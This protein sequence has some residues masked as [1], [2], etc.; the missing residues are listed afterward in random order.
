[1]SNKEKLED[2]LTDLNNMSK[3]VVRFKQKLQCNFKCIE[4]I[5]NI[6]NI[7]KQPATVVEIYIYSIEI[8]H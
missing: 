2:L 7:H 3:D 1:M 8:K 4:R 5:A 6:E